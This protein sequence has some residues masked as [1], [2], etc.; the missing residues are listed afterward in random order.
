MKILNKKVILDDGIF[1]STTDYQK[2]LDDIEQ[3]VYAI[4]YPVGSGGFYLNGERKGNGVKPIKD[5]FI[6]KLNELGWDDERKV[7]NP[8]IRKRKIDSTIELSD[9]RFFGVEWETGNISSSHRAINRL[10]KG[11]LEQDLAGGILILPSREMY[12]YLTDRVG[13]FK[14]LEPYFEL[15]SHTNINGVL[16]IIEIEHDGIDPS[17]PSI[18]KGTDGRALI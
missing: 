13:N 7:L 15:M 18:K 17:V 8:S 16:L 12:N 3:A 10:Q 14:E 5:A 2:I 11:M 9:G 6:E 1:S 4:E